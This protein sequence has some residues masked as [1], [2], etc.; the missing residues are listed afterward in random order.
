MQTKLMKRLLLIFMVLTFV[1]ALMPIAT[2]AQEGEGGEEDQV[3]ETT[4]EEVSAGPLDALGINPGF[5]LAQ[6]VNFLIIFGA[7][8]LTLWGPA[9]RMLNSRSA[10]IQKGLEDAAAAARARQ[11]AEAEADKILAEARSERQ[12]LL[13]EARQQGE[14]VKKGIESEARQESERIRSDAQADALTAR[15]AELA[16]LRDQVLQI[17]SAVAGRVLGETIDAK[18]NNKLVSSFFTNLPDGAKSLSGEVTVTSAMPLTAAEKKKVEGAIKGDSYS[19]DVDPTIL[20][21]LIV[22]SQDKVIDGSVQGGLND[23][24]SNLK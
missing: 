17:S 23:L 7:M 1:M 20:G 24:T 16:D 6:I 19:Y 3:A 10:K 12:K 4:G 9:S 8:T 13:E 21:G 2:F 5:L 14:E 18:K 11:N 22:R 15:D